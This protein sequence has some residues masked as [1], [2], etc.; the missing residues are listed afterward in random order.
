MQKKSLVRWVHSYPQIDAAMQ[1]QL[2]DEIANLP[3]IELGLISAQEVV[4][5]IGRTI[6]EVWT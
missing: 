4:T 5:P 6:G 2:D 1:K 3:K